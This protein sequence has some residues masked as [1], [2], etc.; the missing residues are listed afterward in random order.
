MNTLLNVCQENENLSEHNILNISK[1]IKWN[2]NSNT[3]HY[4][5]IM[6]HKLCK[7]KYVNSKTS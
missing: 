1:Y 5:T 3:C 2:D 4:N 6:I 7:W